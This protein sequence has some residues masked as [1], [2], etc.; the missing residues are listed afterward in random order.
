M[1]AT[2]PQPQPVVAATR[3]GL[4]AIPLSRAFFMYVFPRANSIVKELFKRKMSDVQWQ[5]LD[6]KFLQPHLK[7]FGGNSRSASTVVLCSP[8]AWVLMRNLW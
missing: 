1:F 8:P 2:V 7:S 6:S 3:D 4:R 5:R